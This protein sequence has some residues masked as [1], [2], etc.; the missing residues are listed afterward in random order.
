MITVNLTSILSKPKNIFFQENKKKNDR[1]MVWLESMDQIN[2]KAKVYFWSLM[3]ASSFNLVIYV[4]KV[5]Y[6]SIEL[7][8]IYLNDI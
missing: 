5:H 3:F 2:I 1:V 8:L 6:Y 7:T 4:W